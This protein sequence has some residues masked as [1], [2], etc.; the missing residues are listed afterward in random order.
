MRTLK[1]FLA[2]FMLLALVP[3]HAGARQGN[4]PTSYR[5]PTQPLSQVADLEVPPIDVLSLQAKHKPSPS[6]PEKFAEPFDLQVSTSTDGSWEALQDGSLLWRLRISAPGA[7]DL[8]LGFGY[9]DL[10]EGASLYILSEDYDYFQG[11]YTYEDTGNNN[12][13]WSPVIPGNRAVIELHLPAQT[14]GLPE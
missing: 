7:T 4:P 6:E 9:A 14:Q 11:P 8:N 13:F 12:E 3:L 1:H 10:P 5:V 2:G